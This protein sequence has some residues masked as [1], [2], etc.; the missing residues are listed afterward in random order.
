[1]FIFFFFFKNVQCIY[2]IANHAVSQAAKYLDQSTLFVG[3][4]EDSLKRLEHVTNILTYYTEIF[5]MFRSKVDNYF[6]HPTESIPWNFD[7]ELVLGRIMN[8]QKRLAEI[9]VRDLFLKI[10]L[11]T[12]TEKKGHSCFENTFSF[13]MEILT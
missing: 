8:F 3:D 11:S 7:E 12:H 6:K 5:E 4:V 9:K 2:C 1:M 13:N 10:R